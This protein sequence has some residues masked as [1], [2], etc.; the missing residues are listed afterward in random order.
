MKKKRITRIGLLNNTSRQTKK[1]QERK[2]EREKT[3]ARRRRKRKRIESYRKNIA[4]T[5]NDW[6]GE[7]DDEEEK[8]SLLTSL[9]FSYLFSSWWECVRV[10]H[11]NFSPSASIRCRYSSSRIGE[12]THCS[13]ISKRRKA[14]IPRCHSVIIDLNI[15]HRHAEKFPFAYERS[16]ERFTRPLSVFSSNS[17]SI[18]FHI[19][20]SSWNGDDTRRACSFAFNESLGSFISSLARTHAR[21][22]ISPQVISRRR[23]KEKQNYSLSFSFLSVFSSHLSLS[24]SKTYHCQC[25]FTGNSTRKLRWQSSNHS[26]TLAHLSYLFFFF[27]FQPMSKSKSNTYRTSTTTA[28]L[29]EEIKVVVV[30]KFTWLDW[31]SSF[32][33]ST[34]IS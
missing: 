28:S 16:D 12:Y 22:C 1:T 23:K 15:V 33:N 25:V 26:R 24:L 34:F 32:W 27:F 5:R 20:P 2:R 30:G 10:H 21:V 6:I 13:K 7:Q 31:R 29:A 9:F 17:L 19:H 11:R 18:L 4:P 3:R 14:I 8:G